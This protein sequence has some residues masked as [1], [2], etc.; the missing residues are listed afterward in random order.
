MKIHEEKDA[1]KLTVSGINMNFVF[2]YQVWSEPEGWIKDKGSGDVKMHN[3][4]IG[5]ELSLTS[6]NGAL[7]VDFS[8]VNISLEAYEVKLDGDSDFSRA[9]QIL[10]KNF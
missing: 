6:K 3:S 5:L 8:E 4:D 9:V 2:D 10:F 7:Q 1:L